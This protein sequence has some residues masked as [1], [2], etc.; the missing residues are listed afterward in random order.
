M[1]IERALARRVAGDALERAPTRVAAC[2]ASLSTGVGRT[3]PL[4]S[5]GA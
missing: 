1:L 3:D 2:R 4:A 5:A